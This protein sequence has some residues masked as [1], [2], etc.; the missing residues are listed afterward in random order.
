MLKYRSTG[1]KSR[2]LGNTSHGYLGAELTVTSIWHLQAISSSLREF[3]G[4]WLSA[5]CEM[6]ASCPR[7]SPKTQMMKNSYSD[8]ISIIMKLL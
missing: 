7:D 6:W 4:R 8:M 2:D 3:E 5:R 1:Q